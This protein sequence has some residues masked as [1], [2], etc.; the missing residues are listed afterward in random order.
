MTSPARTPLRAR[1]LLTGDL[2]TVPDTA[3]LATARALMRNLDVRHLPVLGAT[4]LVGLLHE[5]DLA[6]AEGT[7]LE[8]VVRDVPRAQLRD[9]TERLTELLGQSTCAAVVVLDETGRLV[10]VVTERDLTAAVQ[11]TPAGP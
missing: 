7:V 1:D 4:G 6:D 3:S 2:A 11:A 9:G 5:P 10:G 8:R